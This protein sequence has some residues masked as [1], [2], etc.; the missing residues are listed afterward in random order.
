MKLLLKH[1]VD[2]ESRGSEGDT[3]LLFAVREGHESVIELLL[4]K[5]ADPKA[6]S[7]G[8]MGTG[9]TGCTPVI[10]ANA[11]GHKGALK[12]LIEAGG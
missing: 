3:P 4:R 10:V 1:R 11:N 8:W 12:L 5:G 2:L 9:G 7:K 6:G